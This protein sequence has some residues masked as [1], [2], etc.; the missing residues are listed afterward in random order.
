MLRNSAIK[1]MLCLIASPC[2]AF[3]GYQVEILVFSNINATTFNTEHWPASSSDSINLSNT[4]VP[5]TNADIHGLQKVSPSHFILGA[6]QNRIVKFSPY[7]IVLHMAWRESFVKLNQLTK[8]HLYGGQ[9]YDNNGRVIQTVVD[10]SLPYSPTQNW[11]LNGKVALR[12]DRYF[13]MNFNLLFALPN[14]QVAA[15]KSDNLSINPNQF[16][17]IHLTENRRLRS[18]ELNYIDHPLYGVLFKIVPVNM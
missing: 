5:K 6:E 16:T 9:L 11:Q 14:G 8:I 17:Y 18:Q 3:N 13:N 12:L 2:F 1:A 10:E 7:K 4:V 15:L